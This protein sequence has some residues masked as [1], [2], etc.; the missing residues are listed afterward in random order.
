MN[1]SLAVSLPRGLPPSSPAIAS[2]AYTFSDFRVLAGLDLL[3]HGDDVVPLEPRA[4]CVLRH[5]VRHTGRVVGKEELLDEVWPDTFVTDSV[6]K[7]VVSLIRRALGDPPQRSGF[8]ET[9]H[10]R[11]YR[12]MATVHVTAAAARPVDPGRPSPWRRASGL[13]PSSLRRPTSAP[14]HWRGP[15]PPRLR[16]GP[17]R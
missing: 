2:E 4:V 16:T 6:L 12:F 11:G 7:K 14:R 10:R 17:L 8:I 1:T 13:S 5:L 15:S 3:F 9:Y